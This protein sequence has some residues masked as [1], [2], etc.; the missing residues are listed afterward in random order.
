MK[1]QMCSRCGERPA[2]VFIQKMDGDKTVPE[3]LCIKCARE[4]NIGSI[5]QMID[6]MGI[7]DEELELASEQMA[8]FMENMGDF[9]FGNLGEMFNPDNMDGAQTMPFA[10]LFGGSLTPQDDG[11]TSDTRNNSSKKRSKRGKRIPRTMQENSLTRTA[12][13]LPTVQSRAKLII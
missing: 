5:N 4:L 13:T 11:D 12:I 9:D 3:G 8:N 6:K 10:D 1:Q 2:V 7:S